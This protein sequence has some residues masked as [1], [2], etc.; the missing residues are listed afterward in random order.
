MGVCLTVFWAMRTPL[1]I[2]PNRSRCCNFI[3]S[4]AKLAQAV[5]WLVGF[6]VDSF[7]MMVLLSQVF[8][9]LIGKIHH[10]SFRKS[11]C[12]DSS[13]SLFWTKF[14][15]V[16]IT[17]TLSLTSNRDYR[18]VNRRITLMRIKGCVKMVILLLNCL[19]IL[20]PNLYS[21]PVSAQRTNR[22]TG[23]PMFIWTRLQKPRIRLHPLDLVTTE[24]ES[25]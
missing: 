3:P 15:L 19:S 2:G 25:I 1:R 17:I 23:S 10:R 22:A 8:F 14:R 20:N 6:V 16:V 11:L 9:P 7:M 18:T 12:F 5:N 24:Q 4:A 21:W 13:L